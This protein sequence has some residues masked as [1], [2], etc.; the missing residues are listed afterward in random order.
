MENLDV[1]G[2]G[3]LY[4][5]T[6]VEMSALS[7]KVGTASRTTSKVDKFKWVV[8]VDRVDVGQTLALVGTRTV[9]GGTLNGTIKV[10]KG[11]GD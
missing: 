9:G 8:M 3:R 11:C 6:P 5:T 4:I 10:P 1:T 2:T 7:A